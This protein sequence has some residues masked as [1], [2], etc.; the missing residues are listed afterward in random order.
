MEYGSD[1]L[2]PSSREGNASNSFRLRLGD[3]HL[4]LDFLSDLRSSR[5]EAPL[6]MVVHRVGVPHGIRHRALV[7]AETPLSLLL[8]ILTVSG[9]E[10]ALLQI[11]SIVDF[12][13]P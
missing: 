9:C 8:D 2:C 10:D 3:D 4:L 11:F 6:H 12:Y 5:F 1:L 7:C 13:S